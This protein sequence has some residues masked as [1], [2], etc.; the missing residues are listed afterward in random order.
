M[1]Y[2]KFVS[3]KNNLRLPQFLTHFFCFATNRVMLVNIR[4]EIKH[5]KNVSFDII[6]FLIY[7]HG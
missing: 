7:Q 1:C 6:T 3:N 2:L 4:E 5:G